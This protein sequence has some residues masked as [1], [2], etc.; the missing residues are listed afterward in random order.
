VKKILGRFSMDG[1]KPVSTPLGSQFKLTKDQSPK[2]DQEK[3][4]K[5]K[6]PYASV[7]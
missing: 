7:I 3:A 6:V 1:A 2:T 5:S 4:Y